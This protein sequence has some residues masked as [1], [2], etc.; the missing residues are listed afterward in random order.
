MSIRLANADLVLILSLALGGALLLTLRFRPKTW[1]G[2]V[3]EALV[4]NAAAI[5]AMLA[6]EALL[7]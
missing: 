2:I 3:F 5:A 4:A 6:F 7:A 1:L